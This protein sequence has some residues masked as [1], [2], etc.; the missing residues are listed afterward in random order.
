MSDTGIF[1]FG[2]RDSRILCV[3]PNFYDDGIAVNECALRLRFDSLH[4]R[5]KLSID[6]KFGSES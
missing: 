2:E 4:G 1:L 3:G 5:K 6:S